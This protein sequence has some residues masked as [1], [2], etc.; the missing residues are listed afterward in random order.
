[1]CKE[2]IEDV[3]NS[4]AEEFEDYPFEYFSGIQVSNLIKGVYI[5]PEEKRVNLENILRDLN[6]IIG[7]HEDDKYLAKQHL[8]DELDSKISKIAED[9]DINGENLA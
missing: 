2:E 1:M 4:I 6:S 9:Y 7:R 3:I 5:F 8:I